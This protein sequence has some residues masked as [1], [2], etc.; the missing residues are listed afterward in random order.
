M[1]RARRLACSLAAIMLDLGVPCLLART[2]PG[3]TD[4][5]VLGVALVFFQHHHPTR[6]RRLSVLIAG[7]ALAGAAAWALASGASSLG[8]D[9][10]W[11]GRP[12]LW[13][14][15]PLPG[16]LA[17]AL[18]SWLLPRR[19]AQVAGTFGERAFAR[20]A[21]R[22]TPACPYRLDP[23]ASLVLTVSPGPPEDL[24]K[25]IETPTGPIPLH[26]EGPDEGM[27]RIVKL[28]TDFALGLLMLVPATI[29]IVLL[30]AVVR[31]TSAGPA[32]YSQTRVTLGG[33][34]FPILKLRSMR[35]EA[36]ADG[37]P[38]WPAEH[39]PRITALGRFL[40]RFWLDELPQTYNVLAAHLSFVGPRPERPYFVQAFSGPLPKYPLR[41]QVRAGITGLSQVLGCTG[42]TSLARRLRLDLRY[43]RIWSPWLDLRIA[44][45]TVVRALRRPPIRP[46]S[47]R[48]SVSSLPKPHST[49]T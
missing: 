13:F 46:A 21:L 3:P 7:M 23:R 16:H 35:T 11:I 18:A 43:A 39:D 40:R 28:T 10:A 19:R 47:L 41:H 27:G 38:V 26:P 45:W 17:T 36:E 2:L 8:F 1:S 32:F 33:R 22:T 14:V 12:W 48:E 15:A 24:R 34:R 5:L 44:V 42:N 37:V 20:E 9:L 6:R 31:L 30:A 4:I 29:L 49:S 25:V